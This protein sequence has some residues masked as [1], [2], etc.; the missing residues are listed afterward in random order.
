MVDTITNR[1]LPPPGSQHLTET[2]LKGHTAIA[3]ADRT[4]D[5]RQELRNLAEELFDSANIPPG[6]MRHLKR[7]LDTASARLGSH[8]LGNLT[9]PITANTA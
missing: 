7:H 3:C 8:L 1:W 5:D 6:S 2:D 4:D 9:S